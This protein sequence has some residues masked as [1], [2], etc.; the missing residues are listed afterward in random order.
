MNDVRIGKVG[1]KRMVQV[2]VIDDESPLL[3]SIK[4][5]E[6]IAG[7]IQFA[8]NVGAANAKRDIRQALGVY[9]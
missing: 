4:V 7:V 1:K 3:R 6:E 5:T 9:R 2:T 8:L